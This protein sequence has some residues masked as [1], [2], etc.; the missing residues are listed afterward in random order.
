MAQST[1]ISHPPLSYDRRCT[2][3]RQFLSGSHIRSSRLPN[4]TTSRQ[5]LH[6]QLLRASATLTKDEPSTAS[7]SGSG[8]HSNGAVANINW[9]ELGFGIDHMAP[10][11][12]RATYHPDSGWEG[13]LEPYGPLQLDPSAQVLNY[14][15]SVFEGM[16]AQRSAKGNIV[17]FRP[18]ENAARMMAGAER[19]SMPPPPPEV[20]LDAVLS[21]VR[22]NAHY[23]PPR[24]KGSLYLRPLLLGTGPI[25]GLGPAPSY[26]L[27]VYAAAVGAYFKSGQLT[28]IDL[29]VEERFHRAAPGGMGGTKAAGNYSPVLVVQ[30]AAKQSGYAD[31]VYLDARTDTYLE[32]VSSC[33]IFTVKGNVIK[34]PPLAG[35]IL[36]GVTRKSVIQLARQLGYEVQETNVTVNEAMEADEIFTTG[37]AVVVSAVGSLTHRGQRKQFGEPGKPTKTA[38]RIYE[39]LTALQQEAGEDPFGW[40]VPVA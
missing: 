33:N 24:G 36:P 2:V 12:Y 5:R 40:I 28:P 20:F 22:A 4:S 25:L 7:T 31:V 27:V 15:Q 11:M 34:T 37:T 32:E 23:V 39:A 8:E 6:D 38:L 16:K 13:G 26:S 17:L 30:L 1:R 14:G 10:M 18:D 29:I 35:T 21:T 3:V 19:L 9:D